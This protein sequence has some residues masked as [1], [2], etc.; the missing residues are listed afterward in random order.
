MTLYVALAVRRCSELSIGAD[1]S[2]STNA[3]DSI[4]GA[5]RSGPS[6]GSRTASSTVTRPRP[7]PLH[8]AERTQPGSPP[9]VNTI[10]Q[11]V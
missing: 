8:L 5:M 2:A 4:R 11:M 3:Y 9:N 1:G 10:P 7:G 6:A